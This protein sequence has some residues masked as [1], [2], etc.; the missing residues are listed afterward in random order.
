M[1]IFEMYKGKYKVQQLENNKRAVGFWKSFYE[2][3]EIEFIE[4]IEDADGV[5]CYTQVFV[6]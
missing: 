3:N 1:K 5:C 6:Y 2:K 4:T